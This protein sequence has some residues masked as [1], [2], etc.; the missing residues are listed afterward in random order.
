MM[1][2]VFCYLC[3]IYAE[4]ATSYSQEPRVKT[5]GMLAQREDAVQATATPMASDHQN[6]SSAAMGRR[7]RSGGLSTYWT[8]R[9]GLPA[10]LITCYAI[11]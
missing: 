11:F 8:A 5:L 4:K 7:L 1:Q 3:Y 2:Y 10:A 9:W 6:R